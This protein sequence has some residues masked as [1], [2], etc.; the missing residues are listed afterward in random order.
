MSD[1][2][3]GDALIADAGSLADLAAAAK[4]KEIFTLAIIGSAD[5]MFDAPADLDWPSAQAA[6][7]SARAKAGPPSP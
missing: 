7:A 6:I 1:S 2:T 5:P 3:G 4:N